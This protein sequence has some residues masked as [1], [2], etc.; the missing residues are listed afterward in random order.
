MYLHLWR[1]GG[2]GEESTVHVAEI[3]KKPI[4]I[5]HSQFPNQLEDCW[6]VS[7]IT[8]KELYSLGIFMC[9]FVH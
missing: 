8:A 7:P 2:W 9:V 3:Q 5:E 6:D 4:S 1:D